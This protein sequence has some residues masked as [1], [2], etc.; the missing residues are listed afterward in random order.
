[1]TSEEKRREDEVRWWSKIKG[2]LPWFSQKIF[3]SFIGSVSY[4]TKLWKC[5]TGFS[6]F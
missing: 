4:I 2:N 3:L 5:A 6:V 1:M